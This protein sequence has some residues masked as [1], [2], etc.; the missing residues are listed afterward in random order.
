MVQ[1]SALL[2]NAAVAAGPISVNTTFDPNFGSALDAAEAIR[3]KQVSSVE[4]TRS[5][6]QLRGQDRKV[7]ALGPEMLA[8]SKEIG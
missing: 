1:F 7:P 8:S 6:S 3:T 5:R 4:L 2:S